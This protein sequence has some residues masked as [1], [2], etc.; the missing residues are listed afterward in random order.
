MSSINA[1]VAFEP[2]VIARQTSH[3]EVIKSARNTEIQHVDPLA[4][5]RMMALRTLLSIHKQLQYF[6]FT[7]Y[8]DDMDEVST[9]N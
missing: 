1:S 6:F 2:V 7:I 4:N 8:L 9:K 5:Q 3:Y